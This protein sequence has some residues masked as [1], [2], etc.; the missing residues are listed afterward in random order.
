MNKSKKAYPLTKTTRDG[1][2]YEQPQGIDVVVE[3]CPHGQPEI[4]GGTAIVRIPWKTLLNAAQ[5]SSGWKV[6][7]K[8]AP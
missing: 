5:R 6:I 2:W 3:V 1:W 4:Y 8:V 7:V